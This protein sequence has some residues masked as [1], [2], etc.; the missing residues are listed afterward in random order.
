MI[1]KEKLALNLKELK[2]KIPTKPAVYTKEHPLTISEALKYYCNQRTVNGVQACTHNLNENNWPLP[3]WFDPENVRVGFWNNF[4]YRTH[5]WKSKR[6]FRGIKEFNFFWVPVLNNYYF[7]V[8]FDDS[9]IEAFNANTNY[10]FGKLLSNPVLESKKAI[11]ESV[12][13]NYKKSDWIA[14]ISSLFPLLDFV[15]RQILKTTNLSVD[16]SRICRLFA[17]NGFSLDNAGELMPHFTFVISHEP[18]QPLFTDEKKNWLEKMEETDF[19]LIGPTLS[20]F[21]RFA[22]I[23][24]A[25]YREDQEDDLVSLNRHAILHGSIPHFGTNANAVKLLTFFYLV[26]ELGPV[27]D[28]LF[29]E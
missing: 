8:P 23:Y 7:Q 14:C 10:A 22:N 26:L 16:V 9:L 29:A 3:F 24:Y 4:Y 2:N 1:S 27:F 28:I 21:I 17:Q 20:S 18:G 6:K 25:Y 5:Y 15:V 11:L 19:G 13:R 12:R